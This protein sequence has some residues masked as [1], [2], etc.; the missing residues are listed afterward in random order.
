MSG[1]SS[2]AT[3]L[4]WQIKRMSDRLLQ[5]ELGLILA[6]LLVFEL[7]NGGFDMLRDSGLLWVS[8]TTPLAALACFI[9]PGPA[10]VDTLKP[11]RMITLTIS[12]SLGLY[13]VAAP[14]TYPAGLQADHDLILK[15]ADISVV[16]AMLAS[17]VSYWR[18]A[19][20]LVPAATVLQQKAT[21][22]DLFQIG[23]SQTDYI[24]LLEMG[25]FLGLALMLMG[26][27]LPRRLGPL[28]RMIERC[29]PTWAFVL[30]FMAAVSAHFSNYFYSRL[31]KLLLD[32]GPFLWAFSNPTYM[33][34]ASC[35]SVRLPG[36]P[37][38]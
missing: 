35:R 2:R 12:V 38:R 4:V 27:G 11:V 16:I 5:P 21:A 6:T 20:T 24:P 25:L 3:R 13:A 17:I 14:I 29:D 30:V 9:A 33:S 31:Q 19:F 1:M 7:F 8:A 34:R 37:M 10:R 15:L 36:C 18:P 32:G 22:S 26:P 28:S 23:I